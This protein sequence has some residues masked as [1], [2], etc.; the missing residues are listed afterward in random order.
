[1][2][3]NVEDLVLNNISLL[4]MDIPSEL[5]ES[6]KLETADIEKNYRDKEKYWT[7]LHTTGLSS[8]GVPTHFKL[9]ENNEKFKNFL[10]DAVAEYYDRSLYLRSLNYLKTQAPLH[11]QDPWVNLQ[12]AN[13]FFP[14]H[15][16]EGILSYVL[17]V[18]IPKDTSNYK[19]AGKFEITYSDILG[20]TRPT[21]FIVDN[22]YEG[23]LLIF[24]AMLRH[25]VYPFYNS[26]DIRISIAGNVLL[27]E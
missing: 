17:W 27:G 9:V 23:K 24:P 1:M 18:K 5:F 16:H 19:F 22:T 12:K 7:T 14:N 11:F 4:L 3:N 13:E 25:C 20:N 21:E 15:Q 2:I 6:I 8:T 26:D 10:A